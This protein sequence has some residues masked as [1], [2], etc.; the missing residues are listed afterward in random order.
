[1]P[2]PESEQTRPNSV[3]PGAADQTRPVRIHSPIDATQPSNRSKPAEVTQPVQLANPSEDQPQLPID[4]A[5]QNSEGS[6]M[7][8]VAPKGKKAGVGSILSVILLG[9]LGIL[10][11]AAAGAA[12]GYFTAASSSA[13]DNRGL[14]AMDATTQFQ[15]GV[16]DLE[17]G[18]LEIA[19]QRFEYVVSIY[20]DFPGLREKLTEAQVKLQISRVPTVVPTPT[21]TPTIDTRGEQELLNQL[22]QLVKDKKW[23]EAI[24]VIE[25]LRKRSLSY[26]TVEVDGF[27]YLALRG[28]GIDKIL[29]TT[30]LEGGIYD[31]ALAERF[32][33]LDRDAGNTRMWARY[34]LS[35]AS[36][37]MVD[38]EKVIFYFEQVWN[39]APSLRD[40][41]GMTARERFRTALIKYG[42]SLAQ[43]DEFCDA[44]KQY[45]RALQIDKNSALEGRL[46]M[47]YSCSNLSNK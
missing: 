15:L 29:K 32:G 39:A 6:D 22:P 45:A 23:D 31:L 46:S 26:H 47:G 25:S 40:S 24:A 43:K 19:V 10:L 41:S 14:V 16:V 12:L 44:A 36:F 20:P 13:P 5:D 18:R 1:M 2:D 7:G 8:L 17:Q 42:D 34:Y 9:L 11:V 27:Y 37:W 38:W 3:K 4:P 35:G 21:L 28:R 30:D 33:P